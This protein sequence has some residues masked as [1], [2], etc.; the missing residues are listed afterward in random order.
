MSTVIRAADIRAAQA[1]REHPRDPTRVRITTSLGDQVGL[2]KV[3]IHA[4]RLEPN[5]LS[6]VEHYHDGDDEWFFVLKGSG[7][8]LGEGEGTVVNEGD[9][10]GFAA[11]RKIPHAFKA[12]A[13]GME[14]LTGGSRVPM[15][16]TH[17]PGIGKSLL[18]N[19]A[20]GTQT[21]YEATTSKDVS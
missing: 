19:I 11:G 15:D 13:D 12:G 14:Y 20:A 21:L 10:V 16:M 8:L 3:G 9:F 18:V 4:T 7:L 2:T 5:M 17:Y 1:P 6:T